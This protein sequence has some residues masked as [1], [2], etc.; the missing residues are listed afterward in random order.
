M[1]TDRL[2]PE[3]VVQSQELA[4]L[5]VDDE[6]QARKYFH[7]AFAKDF[8]VL[9]AP[10]ADEGERLLGEYQGEIA[11]LVSDQRMPR[12][13]GLDLLKSTRRK[14]P[15]VVRMLTT[16][17]AELDDAM[18]AV[19]SGEVFR[20]LVKP[21]KL[22]EV[23]TALY[24]ALGLYLQRR[25]DRMLVGEKRASILT[26][27]GNIAHEL[28]TPLAGVRSGIDGLEQYLPILL[29]A[30][31][32]ARDENIN[33]PDIPAHKLAAMERILGRMTTSVNTS[34]TVI[35]MLLASIRDPQGMSS[36]FASHDMQTCLRQA[37]QHYPFPGE[38]RTWLEPVGGQSFEFFGSD[39]LL[40]HVIYNLLKNAIDAIRVRGYSEERP[41][42][43]LQM[44]RASPFNRLIFEDNGCGIDPDLMPHIFEDF[45]AGRYGSRSGN[46]LGLSFCRRVL[47]VFGGSINCASEPGKYTRFT[48]EFPK[49]WALDN[50]SAQSGDGQ[51]D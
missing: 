26:V 13:R 4:V 37:M 5:F 46:G 31:R 7:K 17:Y 49:D 40:I 12:R 3:Q 10:D 9:T 25:Y 51:H 50:Q 44:E 41:H 27:A 6:P 36:G 30:Y 28:R 14:H 20:Y 35:D 2:S 29:D 34:S 22:D 48:M 23:R 1:T 18:E 8:Q 11:I 38:T 19:N 43:R 15:D 33:I 45:V 42:I 21:W 32:K 16:A 39:T 47:T 24:D